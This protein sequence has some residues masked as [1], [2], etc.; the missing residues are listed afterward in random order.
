MKTPSLKT[1]FKWKY[2]QELQFLCYNFSHL[3]LL[4]VE[5]R[6]RSGLSERSNERSD[7]SRE[8]GDSCFKK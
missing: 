8:R 7:A 3:R 1:I 6:A 2:E 4:S 5:R